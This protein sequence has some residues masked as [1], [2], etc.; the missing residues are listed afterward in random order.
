MFSFYLLSQLNVIVQQPFTWLL[1]SREGRCFFE[2]SYALVIDRYL[3]IIDSSSEIA[4]FIP[5]IFDI[6]EISRRRNQRTEE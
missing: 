6:S 4:A 3:D 5:N 1:C 2:N